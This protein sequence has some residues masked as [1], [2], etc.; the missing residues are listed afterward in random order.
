MFED[1]QDRREYEKMEGKLYG[2]GV[3]SDASGYWDNGVSDEDRH[4]VLRGS[5]GWE[6]STE[7]STALGGKGILSLSIL[8]GGRS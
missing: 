4:C 7:D 5:T 8:E 2:G 6:G 3:V 1:V